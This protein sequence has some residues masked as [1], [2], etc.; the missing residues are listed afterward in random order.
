MKTNDAVIFIGASDEQVAWGGNDD[1]R[2]HLVSG[3]SYTIDRI[4][5]H[6]WHTKIY[7]KEFP[8]KKFN[9]VCFSENENRSE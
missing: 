9:S 7:L 1:P 6:N 2:K 5:T 4:E 8:G 3:E